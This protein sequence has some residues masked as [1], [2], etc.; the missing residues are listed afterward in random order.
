MEVE[1]LIVFGIIIGGLLLF[2]SGL[3]PIDQTSIIIMVS[4]MVTGILTPEEGVA[5][6]SNT[7]TITV[8]AL[9]ILSQGLRNTGVVDALGDQLLKV[10]GNRAWTSV[11]AIMLLVAFSSAFINTTAVVAV[12]IPIMFKISQRAKIKVAMLLIPLSFAGMVGGASTMIGTSTNLLVNSAARASGVEGF[13]IFELTLLGGILLVALIVYMLFVGIRFLDKKPRNI[14]VFDKELE[15]KNYLTELVVTPESELIGQK[16]NELKLYDKTEYKLQRLLRKNRVIKPH[17]DLTI[18][19][20]DVLTIKTDIHEIINI[21]NNPNLRILTNPANKHID[22]E[23][24]DDR[25]LFEALIVPNS[26]LI[27]RKIKNVQFNRFYDAF[28]LAARRGGLIG[29]QKLMDH[30]IDVGD[31]LLMDGENREETEQSKHDWVIIQR[32]SKEEIQRQI[33]SRKLM[34]IS[35]TILAM[36]IL[37]A[38]TNVFPILISAWLGVALMFITGCISVKKAYENVEWKVIFLL[39][40]IIPLGTALTKTGGDQMIA[41]FIVSITSNASPRMVVSVLFIFTTL[42]TGIISNQ[43]TAIL[44]V[45]IAVKIATQLDMP[46][47]PLLVAILFGAN[48]SFITPVGYQTNAMIYGPGNYNFKDFVKVGGLLSIIFWI[49]AT[50]LIPVLYM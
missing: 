4:L 10:T 1:L 46:P 49:I 38:V 5:G 28:P 39:A 18:E 2:V 22:Q 15:A 12:F 40:G 48:T 13:K 31:I 9:L 24:A 7:A 25:L 8:L 43:A 6:F 3:I 30:Q 17:P 29:D 45:P 32:I 50:I 33:L 42:L 14:N 21:N 44:L 11:L 41:E 27:G 34:A 36:V 26:N 35:I 19:E 23:E 37:L 47:E 16:F 20:G